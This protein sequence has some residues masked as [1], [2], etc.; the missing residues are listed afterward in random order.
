M[1]RQD[2]IEDALHP[3]KPESGYIDHGTPAG[4]PRKLPWW[5]IVWNL[6]RN[7]VNELF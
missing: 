5:K 4:S 3:D 1:I 2:Y 6:I 7:L